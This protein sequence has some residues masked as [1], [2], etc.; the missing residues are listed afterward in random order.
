[1]V[2]GGPD[3]FHHIVFIKSVIF[4]NNLFTYILITNSWC[5]CI[6]RNQGVNQGKITFIS[7]FPALD[8]INIY[9]C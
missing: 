9:L 6:H 4:I 7:F 3:T 5:V 1:M 8:T 2:Y